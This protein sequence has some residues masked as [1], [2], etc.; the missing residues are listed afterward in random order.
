MKASEPFDDTT[1]SFYRQLFEGWGL[2][3]ETEREVFF[4]GA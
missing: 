3:V 2:T 1:K 4:S